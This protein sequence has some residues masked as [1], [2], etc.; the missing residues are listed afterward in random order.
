[1]L[2]YPTG[3]LLINYEDVARPAMTLRASKKFAL[4]RIQNEQK[5][6]QSLQKNYKMSLR[7]LKKGSRK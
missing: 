7:I 2:L 4:R 5:P 1:G 6:F 3:E